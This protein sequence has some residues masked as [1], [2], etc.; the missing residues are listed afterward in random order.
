MGKELLV[1]YGAAD[2]VVCVAKANL[3]QFLTEIKENKEVRLARIEIKEVS[4]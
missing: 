2:S 1:Y 4:Y 3:N